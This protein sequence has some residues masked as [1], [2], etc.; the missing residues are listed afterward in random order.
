ME[1]P[2]QNTGISLENCYK[3]VDNIKAFDSAAWP[4]TSF[5]A[6]HSAAQVWSEGGSARDDHHYGRRDKHVGV[7]HVSWWTQQRQPF[8][9][10]SPSEILWFP[11]EQGQHGKFKYF[12]SVPIGHSYPAPLCVCVC[13]C[14]LLISLYIISINISITIMRWGPFIKG[15]VA[16]IDATSEKTEHIHSHTLMRICKST[17]ACWFSLSHK[18]YQCTKEG[19]N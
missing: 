16:G 18:W 3:E 14:F 7:W 4:L 8:E 15:H 19:E 17:E 1:L 2:L 10:D 12:G 11:Q 13:V 9:A 5:L 6:V